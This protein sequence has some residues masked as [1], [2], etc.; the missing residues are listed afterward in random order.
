LGAG[1]GVF[2]YRAFPIPGSAQV[3]LLG[4]LAKAGKEKSGF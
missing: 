4:P 1:H 3:R 2:G